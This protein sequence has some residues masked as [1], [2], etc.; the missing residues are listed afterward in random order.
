MAAVSADR[1]AADYDDRLSS[2]GDRAPGRYVAEVAGLVVVSLGVEAPWGVQVV[3]TDARPDPIRVAA[4]VAWCRERG[5]DPQVRVRGRDREALATYRVVEELAA[6][7]ALAGAEQ[8][9][10]DVSRA[11]DVEMFRALYAE[12]F[13]M[14]PGLAQQLVVAADLD[15][16]PHMV[17]RVGGQPVVCAQVRAGRD[18]AYVGGV[19]VLP[20]HRRRGYGAAMLAACRQQAAALG[21]KTVWLNAEMRTAPFY[22]AT[23]FEV[24][25]THLALA[26]S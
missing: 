26:A 16:L 23:G 10:L 8:D 7:A 15:A 13:G 3:A 2:Y 19:G 18:L 11:D 9:L 12:S 21:C 1:V 20:A 14:P 6:L 17:G 22:E 5:S 4:A 25:D 24:V